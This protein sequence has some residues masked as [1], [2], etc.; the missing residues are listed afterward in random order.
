[1][2]NYSPVILPTLS[3]FM[4][5][6]NKFNVESLLL[7]SFFILG[8]NY[9][10]FLGLGII[11]PSFLT[12]IVRA[13]AIVILFFICYKKQSDIKWFVF[14]VLLML[15][16]VLVNKNKYITNLIV[17]AF[18]INII[19]YTSVET[20]F[21]YIFIVSLSLVVVHFSLFSLGFLSNDKLMMYQIGERVRFT[22]GF[23]NPNALAVFYA[24]LFYASYYYYLV[25]VKKFTAFSYIIFFAAFVVMYLSG[26]R[27]LF[28]T[29]CIFVLIS[30]I[31]RKIYYNRLIRF[32]FSASPFIFS[33][34]TLFVAFQH[35]SS[36][37]E[38]L[39]LRP[40]LFFK[41]LSKVDAISVLV[42]LEYTAEDLVDNAYILLF[43]S[44][45]LLLYIGLLSVISYK[46]SIARVEYLP[47]VFV[48]LA[49]SLFESFLFRPEFT[50]TMLFFACLFSK[51][52]TRGNNNSEVIIVENIYK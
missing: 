39:S 41:F 36:L 28:Y 25:V 42:G 26:S 8:F 51:S 32:L 14:F 15:F 27:T 2:Q 19:K 22:F 29:S 9:L 13:I 50:I 35:E 23:S 48:V 4:V 5:K 34:L 31:P 37:N 7:F 45:G 46:I 3:V 1:M 24:S 17:I 18:L 44:C 6:K 16:V 33:I 30:L 21:R 52:Q 12:G 38:T 11:E 43:A 47:F 20:L 10:F 49:S 40:L